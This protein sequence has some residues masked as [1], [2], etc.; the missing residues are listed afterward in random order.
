MRRDL[1]VVVLYNGSDEFSPIFDVIRW[2]G[3]VGMTVLLLAVAPVGNSPTWGNAK[4]QN[5]VNNSIGVNQAV[6]LSDI[7]QSVHSP[8][9]EHPF[10][11]F[12]IDPAKPWVPKGA[13]RERRIVV[14]VP[15]VYSE[16]RWGCF[17]ESAGGRLA[18]VVLV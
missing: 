18:T 14:G 15:H 7:N 9:I 5:H 8:P 1:A 10:G 13:D 6:A 3:A 11:G 12:Q 2:V 16:R 17:T 4:G